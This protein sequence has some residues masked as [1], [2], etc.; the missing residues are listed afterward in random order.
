MTNNDTSL[1][2]RGAGALL[3]TT[4]LLM[5]GGM[6]T[7]PPQ[8]DD[9]LPAYLASLARDWDLSILSASLL[10]YYWVVLALA[11]PAAVTLLR[12]GR[13]RVLTQ[14]GVAATM[15]GAIQMSGLLF[16]DWFNAA[17]PGVVGLDTAVKVT[18]IVNGDPSMAVWLQTGRVFGLLAP[19]LLMAGLARNGVLGWW[20]VP[21]VVLPIVGGPIV[22]SFA[23]AAGAVVGSLVGALLCAPFVIAGLRLLRR[24]AADVTAAETTLSRSC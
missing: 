11:V 12:G 2:R 18:E 7:S 10:H 17:M 5:F 19:A 13:G 6:V 3:L 8:D 9:S 22:G 15:L 21:V 20:T 1:L 23:G 16:A 4:P 14:V 24:A